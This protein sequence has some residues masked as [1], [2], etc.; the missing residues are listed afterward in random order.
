MGRIPKH[1][2]AA[3][4]FTKEANMGVK[5]LAKE[6]K[7]QAQMIIEDAK[8]Q[9]LNAIPA[10]IETLKGTLNALA[11]SALQMIDDEIQKQTGYTRQELGYIT[12]EGKKWWKKM[13]T[14]K[15]DADKEKAKKKFKEW[16]K[17]QSH[18]VY[19]AFFAVEI[20]EMIG[21]LKIVASQLF[22]AGTKM[23]Q[24]VM[25]L[26]N[27]I[28]EFFKSGKKYEK[29]DERGEFDTAYVG[30]DDALNEMSKTKKTE[31]GW[32][33][34]DFSEKQITDL[35]QNLLDIL[36][37]LMPVLAILL[38]LFD[39][40][41]TN[42]KMLQDGCD[43]K[44]DK[45]LS[46]NSDQV[47]LSGKAPFT[48]EDDFVPRFSEPKDPGWGLSKDDRA[49]FEAES[50]SI[51]PAVPTRPWRTPEEQFPADGGAMDMWS[52]QSD[53]M[54]FSDESPIDSELLR[55]RLALDEAIKDCKLNPEFP[56]QSKSTPT[57]GGKVINLKH[58]GNTELEM[59]EAILRLNGGARL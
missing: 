37:A 29:R 15:K 4:S 1:K 19:N 21:Q 47:G 52:P 41:L 20:K 26:I 45:M 11:D 33:V 3:T 17:E 57:N 25:D 44:T 34:E 18:E 49:T 22:D 13:K 5:A 30:E 16:L 35:G 2:P 50:D 53:Y 39:N 7:L 28:L 43:A 23:V 27:D 10:G 8:M 58:S 32:I 56:L 40:Y 6:A 38:V 36:N 54:W 31:E 55:V 59:E 24:E 51:A 9:A 12:L 14:A 46:Q 42:K 48:N